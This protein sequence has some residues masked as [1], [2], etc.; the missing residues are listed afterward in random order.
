MAIMDLLDDLIFGPLNI[1]D[2]LEGLLKATR[3]QERGYRMTIPRV[4]KGGRHS[5][6]AVQQL[7]QQYGVV[8]YG[9]THDGQSIHFSVKKR[10]ARWA[11]YLLLHAGVELTSATFDERNPGY[12]DMHEAGW[13][14]TPWSEQ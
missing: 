6:A 13:M 8:T 3:Y 2:R 12:V 14:P 1:I 7:L 10:Q 11:E 5:L 9:H 4:D